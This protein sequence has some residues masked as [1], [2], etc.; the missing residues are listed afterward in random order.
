MQPVKF[1]DDVGYDLGA[2][3]DPWWERVLLWL[4]DHLILRGL[5]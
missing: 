1:N 4:C 2:D 3:R 5:R